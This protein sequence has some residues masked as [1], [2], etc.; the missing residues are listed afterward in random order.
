[1]CTAHGIQL[2]ILDVLYKKKAGGE[3]LESMECVVDESVERQ[4]AVPLPTVSTAAST[5][6]NPSLLA[7]ESNE[8]MELALDV[9]EI[10]ETGGLSFVDDDESEGG[11]CLQ[12]FP[13]LKENTGNLISRVR[14]VICLFK[15]SPTKNDDFLQ[16]Y[17][18]DE[19]GKELPLFLDRKT[20]WSSLYVM[21]E[22]FYKI[23]SAVRKALIDLNL[24]PS[25]VF[26]EYEFE[27]IGSIVQALEV[28]KVTVA[29]LCRRDS[30][31]LTADAALRFMLRKLRA[32]KLLSD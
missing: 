9:E 2:G 21:L 13:E 7:S 15:H 26:I 5:S 6:S 4:H 17:V 22:R 31:L 12:V 3:Q 14:K 28:V 24:Q 25:I 16:K 27:H 29:V 30:N 20:R 10:D 8:A 11:L 18:R 1:M 23:R 19:F 32:Q